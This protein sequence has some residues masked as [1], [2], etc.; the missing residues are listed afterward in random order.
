VLA[1]DLTTR[2]R[3]R[4]MSKFAPAMSLQRGANIVLLVAFV[5][6]TSS[7][8]SLQ[9]DLQ[10]LI[11]SYGS[12]SIGLQLGWKSVTDEFTIAAGSVTNPGESIRNITPH[13]TFNY[14]SGTKPTI[15]TA[16][17]RMVDAGKLKLEDKVSQHVDPFLKRN[18]GTTLEDLFG[19]QVAEASV[20][21]LL[22]MEAGLPDLGTHDKL[23]TA[24]LNSHGQV[25]S[26]Y[27][28][29]RGYPKTV[30]SPGACSYYSSVSYIVAGLLVTSVQ[31]PTGDW[32]D[33]DFT[34]AVSGST[35][36]RYP[37]MKL[38]AAKGALHDTMSVEGISYSRHS[39]S[40]AISLWDQNP[41]IMGWACGGMM[42]NTGDVA[43]FFYDLIAPASTH[44]LV[45][46]ASLKE[47][48]NLKPLN[49]GHFVVDY[50]AGLMDSAA[51][52]YNK[53]TT[54]GPDD[55]SYII[56]HIGETFAFHAVSG[57]YPK[58]QAAISIVTNSDEGFS[59][60]D[61]IACKA[62]EIA[63]KH[64]GVKVNVGCSSP[65]PSPSPWSPRRRHAGNKRASE[66]IV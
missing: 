15:A 31:K 8:A 48:S 37:S 25:F 40:A 21:Q 42:A 20:L 51:P 14:G 1:Q 29:M 44:K 19:S 60:P 36:S 43:R 49:T 27:A 41:S 64:A 55:W 23:N 56:G 26:P 52:R 16:V 62:S 65:S 3:L 45:S 18:N 10:D 7:E 50:G 39:T 5:L 17:F 47:M 12:G 63:A 11:D 6:A 24:A 38:P 58:A 46:D 59:Y 28:W 30:C 54:K 33:L 4:A 2:A 35:K 66:T 57:Y 53:P 61:E 32:V 22:R 34:M 9:S 13:D